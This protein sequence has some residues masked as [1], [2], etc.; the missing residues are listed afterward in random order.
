MEGVLA[1][2]DLCAQKLNGTQVDPRI[3][4]PLI[5]SLC[6]SLKIFGHQL[7]TLYKG[8]LFRSLLR[9]HFWFLDNNYFFIV[10]ILKGV[11]ETSNELNTPTRV[12]LI[13][14]VN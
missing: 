2:M 13:K 4:Q 10:F 3:L 12:I 6:E 9:F 14:K 7:E 5:A 1:D 11:P 8:K